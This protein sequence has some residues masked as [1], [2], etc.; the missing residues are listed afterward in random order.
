[1]VNIATEKAEYRNIGKRLWDIRN[2][3]GLTL[4]ECA[5]YL[6]ISIVAYQYYESGKRRISIDQLKKIAT[7]L[8]CP[9]TY[10]I[11][12]PKSQEPQE[13]W[14]TALEELQIEISKPN[15]RTWLSK[16]IGL[17]YQDNQFIIGVPNTFAAEYLDKNQRLLI[18]KT[19]SKFISPE[20]KVLFHV[21][22]RPQQVL[23]KYQNNSTTSSSSIIAKLNSQYS[24]EFFIEGDSNRLAR[25][26]SLAVANNPGHSYN[27]LFIY[28]GVGLGKTHLLHAIG[29]MAIAE[30]ISVIYSSAEQFTNEFISAL[31]ERRI[32]DFRNK[33]RSAGMLLLDDIQFIIGKEMTEQS[34]VETFNEMYND[35]RQIVLASDRP[36]RAMP[37]LKDRLRSRFEWGLIV[38]IQPPDFEMRLA[39]LQSKC[40]RVGEKITTEVLEFIAQ[41]AT[42]NVRE[43]EGSLNRVI[44]F[45]ELHRIAPTIDLAVRALGDE[46]SPI[47]RT[48]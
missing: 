39:I 12:D 15:Y 41:Q 23:I 34:V 4:E 38:D 11:G 10:L 2:T 8:K 25:A 37:S 17:S 27:P 3:A 46:V 43:L 35:K 21:N 40:L 1:M 19:L 14:E 47:L 33:Y 28:G 44:A 22:E 6:G 24:F 26:A 42:S 18:E 30:N 36:P 13:I 5:N 7:H 29:Q 48:G 20:T 32:E 16:T 45:S 9:V 31:R